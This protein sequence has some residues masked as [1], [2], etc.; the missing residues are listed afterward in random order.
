MW[1]LIKREIKDNIIMFLLVI[2]LA[3]I[4][5]AVVV[6]GFL[7]TD[8]QFAPVGIPLTVYTIF[9]FFII[10]LSLLAVMMGGGQMYLDKSRKISAFLGTLSVTRRGLLWAKFLTDVIWLVV[11]L[12]PLVAA[13]LLLFQARP[14]LIPVDYSLLVRIYIVTSLCTLSCYLLGLNLGL[15]RNRIMAILAGALLCLILI[16]L[17]IIKGFGAEIMLIFGITSATLA[18]RAWNVFMSIPL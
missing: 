1:T 7:R 6:S 5:E 13:E 9:P 8:T 15:G 2:I 16:S 3:G 17:I 14:R 4:C 11:A 12:L 10:P 18:I